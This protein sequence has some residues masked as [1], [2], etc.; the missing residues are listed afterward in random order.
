MV[1]ASSGSLPA[2]VKTRSA[3]SC[4]CRVIDHDHFRCPLFQVPPFAEAA[5]RA[6]WAG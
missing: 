1:R 2:A 6:G 5:M 4:S 3:I